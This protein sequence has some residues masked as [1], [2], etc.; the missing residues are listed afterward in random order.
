LRYVGGV[1]DVDVSGSQLQAT[2]VIIET[3]PTQPGPYPE[4]GTTPDVESL[5]QGSGPAW[6]LRNGMVEE[7][8]WNCP[9]YGDITTYRFPDGRTMTLAPGNTWIELVPN[10]DYPV[11]IQH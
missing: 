1:P 4:S 10:Q 5:T 7:G 11:A 9:A 8:T 3:V 6:V 2:N